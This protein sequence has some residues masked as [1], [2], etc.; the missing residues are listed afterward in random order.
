VPGMSVSHRRL[1]GGFTRRM[2]RAVRAA[3][4]AVLAEGRGRI[5]GVR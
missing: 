1:T 5:S 2:I 3:I 4:R